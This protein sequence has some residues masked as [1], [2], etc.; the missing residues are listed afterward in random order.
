M[1]PTGWDSP[2]RC[3]ILLPLI[4]AGKLPNLLVN[5]GNNIVFTVY[6]LA[7]KHKLMEILIFNRYLCNLSHMIY[8]SDKTVFHGACL[9]MTCSFLFSLCF[10]KEVQIDL[11]LRLLHLNVISTLDILE[12]V[13]CEKYINFILSICFFFLTRF[14]IKVKFN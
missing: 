13:Q 1:L 5:C 11:T 6:L 7:P 8:L 3:I 4:C 2:L 14:C 9:Q 12:N 10:G